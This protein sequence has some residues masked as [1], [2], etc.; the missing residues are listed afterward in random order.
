MKNEKRWKT[1]IGWVIVNLRM[2]WNWK[3]GTSITSWWEYGDNLL[4]NGVGR[5]LFWK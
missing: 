4:L 2:F 1:S 5:P 3:N